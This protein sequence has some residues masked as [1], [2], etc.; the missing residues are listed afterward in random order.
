M[1][2]YLACVSVLLA[3]C[4]GGDTGVTRVGALTLRLA[5]GAG[6]DGAI[7]VIVS[8]G[9]VLSVD[10]SAG[11]QVATNTDGTGTHV[12]VVGNLAAGAI[13]TINVPDVSQAPAY[14]ATV[15]QVADRTSFALLDPVRYQVTIG[16]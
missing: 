16:K 8:G 13:A 15:V 14:V 9:A 5:G 7:V 1:R 6:N 3:A 10:A 2:R 12:M 4:A 11:Y